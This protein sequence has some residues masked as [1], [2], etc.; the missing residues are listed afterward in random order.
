MAKY[1]RVPKEKDEIP[2]DEV[3]LTMR[4]SLGVYINR[5]A[6]LMLRKKDEPEEGD[7]APLTTVRLKGAG[8]VMSKVAQVANI[9]VHKIKGLH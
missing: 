8:M 6:Q 1:E 3:R 5:V 4:S 9:I 2:E 7:P